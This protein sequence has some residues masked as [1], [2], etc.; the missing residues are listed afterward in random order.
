MHFIFQ[1]VKLERGREW[2]NFPRKKMTHFS[3][4]SNFS[5]NSSSCE[6]CNQRNFRILFNLWIIY[7]F[8]F[9]I[10]FFFIWEY[11]GVKFTLKIFLDFSF[12]SYWPPNNSQK[13]IFKFFTLLSCQ[14]SSKSHQINPILSHLPKR[15]FFPFPY[16]TP[17]FDF[18]GAFYFFINSCL[19]SIQLTLTE[20]FKIY[21]GTPWKKAYFRIGSPSPWKTNLWTRN[22]LHWRN[23][24]YWFEP[25]KTLS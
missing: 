17:I 16:A 22:H 7:F 13:F 23:P 3:K 11:L 21:A 2:K 20:L 12:Y 10:K 14:V 8:I 18:F 9:F 25:F 1:I 4:N 5:S 15:N 19:N 6:I 24:D